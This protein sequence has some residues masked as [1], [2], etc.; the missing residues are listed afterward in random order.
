MFDLEHEALIEVGSDE[1]D[2]EGSIDRQKIEREASAIVEGLKS[3]GPAAREAATAQAIS[4]GV[5]P[6]LV[7]RGEMLDNR[8]YERHGGALPDLEKCVR[9]ILV[10]YRELQSAGSIEVISAEAE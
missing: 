6:R 3:Q 7:L 4:L 1:D 2:F 10:E 8:R 9:L 5:I